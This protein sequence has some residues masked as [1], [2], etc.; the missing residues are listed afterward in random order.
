LAGVTLQLCVA[1]LPA[2]SLACNVNEIA[3]PASA[4]AGVQ[5]STPELNVAPAGGVE[6]KLIVT[7]P[8]EKLVGHRFDK[9]VGEPDGD[10]A[11]RVQHQALQI[12]GR[13]GVSGGEVGEKRQGG[14]HRVFPSLPPFCPRNSTRA[15]W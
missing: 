14:G 10:H 9:Q 8:G 7:V 6:V 13:G 2:P 11:E 3:C 12:L 5:S 4:E 1:V 15:S